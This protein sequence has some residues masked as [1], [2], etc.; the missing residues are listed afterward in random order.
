MVSGTLVKIASRAYPLKGIERNTAILV[1]LIIVAA[2]LSSIHVGSWDYFERSGSLIVIVG[3][4]LAW[5]DITG[6]LDSVNRFQAQKFRGLKP[7]GI[8][9]SAMHPATS[10]D[11]FQA[12]VE[13][14]IEILK[15]RVRNL[16][17]IVLATGTFIWGYG[18]V[19]GNYLYELA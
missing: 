17:A 16:E 3:I 14:S 2:L 4:Y 6:K 13:K 5:R 8:I 12:D 7:K 1:F 11:A 9:N 19:L 15:K 18:S 10:E